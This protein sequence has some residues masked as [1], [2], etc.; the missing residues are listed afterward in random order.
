MK[1][2]LCSFL[3]TSICHYSFYQNNIPLR[4]KSKKLKY[5]PQNLDFK[6]IKRSDFLWHQNLGSKWQ[7]WISTDQFKIFKKRILCSV[8]TLTYSI[9]MARDEWDKNCLA[10]RND[11]CYFLDYEIMFSSNFF[12]LRKHKKKTVKTDLRRLIFDSSFTSQK[13]VNSNAVP[14]ASLKH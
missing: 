7:W 2:C 11:C 8:T 12:N 9:N 5:W 4:F 3:W 10:I 14:S 13:I 6:T 1:L